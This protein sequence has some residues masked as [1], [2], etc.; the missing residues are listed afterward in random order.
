MKLLHLIVGHCTGHFQEENR[1]FIEEAWGVHK[2]DDAFKASESPYLQE[3]WSL[4]S[5]CS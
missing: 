5:S 3:K 1:P 2:R 4:D